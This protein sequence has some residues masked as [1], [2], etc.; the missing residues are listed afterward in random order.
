M[1][2]KK[3]DLN[4]FVSAMKSAFLKLDKQLHTI[5]IQDVMQSMGFHNSW[6]NLTSLK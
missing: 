1:L 4:E 3:S 6:T 5:S 2:L